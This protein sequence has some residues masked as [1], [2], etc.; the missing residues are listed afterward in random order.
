MN[1][2]LGLYLH[3]PFCRQRCHFCAFYLEMYRPPAAEAFLHALHTELRLY[4]DDRDR[5]ARPVSSVYF[6]GGTPTVLTTDQL[7]AILARI[8][9]SFSL[10]P[11]CEI[12]VEAH[13][14]TVHAIDLRELRHAGVTRLSFGAESMHDDELMGIGRPGARAETIAAVTAGRAAGFTNINLDLMYGLPGQTIESW[15]QTLRACCELS[16]SHLSCYS[17]T[18]EEG[19][20]FARDIH[21]QA[22]LAPDDTLQIEMDQTAQELLVQAG[23]AQY[24]VSN[25]AKPGYECRH[26][27]LYWTQGNYIGLGPSAQS[28]VDGVRF[29]NVADLMAYQTALAHGRLPVLERTVLTPEEE[30]RDAVIFGLRLTRGIPTSHL[31]R[32]GENY[33]YLQAI[34]GLRAVN[35]LEEEGERTRLSAQGRLLAD[36]V[37][38][39]LF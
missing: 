6:G 25:Y 33:G 8:R 29:G 13:P 27:L 16:P 28:Y 5:E 23:Y 39:K 17:L 36:T 31:H 18:V 19:T 37:A 21:R 38:E 22:S 30:L 34:D 10:H 1:T 9:Q 14:G 12:T 7:A 2:P 35:L 11:D 15:K 24:E 32:H 26:N 4:G 3:I 20:R